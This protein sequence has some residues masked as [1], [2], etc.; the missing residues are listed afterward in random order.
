METGNRKPLI[1]AVDDSLVMLKAITSVLNS[2]YKIFTLPN[3][4]ELEKVLK[5]LTP[6]LFLLDYKMPKISGF[7]LVPIIRGVKAHKETPI[8]FLTSEGTM[9]NV[10][11]AMALGACD[12]V[13][14]PFNPDILREKIARHLIKK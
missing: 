4:A 13:V 7:D 6:D 2:E 9:D 14:K 12:F 5:K 3:P 8:I 1:L 10:T 11:V